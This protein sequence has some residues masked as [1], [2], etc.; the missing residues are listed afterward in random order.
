MELAGSIAKRVSLVV[1]NALK[2]EQER[3]LEKERENDSENNGE[4]EVTTG[5]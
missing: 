5:G 3:L 4:I 1:T 2:L